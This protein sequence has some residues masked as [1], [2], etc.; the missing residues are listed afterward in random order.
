MKIVVLLLLFI[1]YTFCATVDKAFFE[2]DNV[3]RYYETVEKEINST[4]NQKLKDPKII[5]LE[6][7]T[8]QKLKK[9]QTLK[10]QT[11]SFPFRDLSTT[12]TIN[13]NIYLNTLYTLAKLSVEIQNLQKKEKEFQEKLFELK[14]KIEKEVAT[15]EPQ[16]TLLSDQ[17]Q[18]AF[19]KISKEKLSKTRSL[20]QALFEKE[21]TKFQKAFPRVHFARK[22]QAEKIID[23][24]NK[25]IQTL[26][27]KDILLTIDKDSE[28]LH[29]ETKPTKIEE[30]EKKL[31]KETQAVL[32]KKMRTYMLLALQYLQQNNQKEYLHT[33]EMLDKDI[34]K[35]EG[36][37]KAL[38][39]NAA[40]LILKLGEQHSDSTSVA[41][42]STQIGF[43]NI[44]QNLDHYINKTLFVYEEK[45]FS[46]KTIL[47]FAFI[48]A[49][50]FI[51][52]KIYKNFV[53]KFRKTNRIKSLSTARMVANS[54]YYIIILA[55]F[56]IALKTIGLDMHTIFIVIGAILLWLA[57]GLQSFISNYAIG[58]LLRID[59]SIR[60][61]DHI[62][63]DPQT[64]GDVDDMNFRSITI[65]SS[66]NT[67]TTIPN[68][69]FISGTFINHTLEG[70]SRRL[71]V[72]FSADKKIPHEEIEYKILTALHESDLPHFAS[73]N[74]QAQVVIVDINRKIVRYALLVWVP[75]ELTY[76]MT[77][78]Q[79]M[80]LKLIHS[81]LYPAKPNKTSTDTNQP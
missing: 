42:A 75:K 35:L 65:R 34:Q 68:S 29:P 19:Y 43:K 9:L 27:K 73:E 72:Q 1:N 51:V 63:L 74:K 3:L 18:Y 10:T 50:G 13:A 2:G 15:N 22:T 8:L 45:A 32:S 44:I 80:Y 12:G 54:G 67:R 37:E 77:L 38:L 23:K 61:G 5:E 46:I 28:V 59:R 40:D 41:I 24:T 55:T 25:Q 20:Y 36:E 6:R 60:I 53:D 21:F 70:I 7:S 57:F 81:A 33:M 76:D 14:N 30:N 16:S 31:Q 49:I 78:A 26:E 58:T 47:I 66:D 69:R 62:E 52:A 64:A 48:L 11:K 39:N 79:S 4:I 71:Q 56:F 17:M